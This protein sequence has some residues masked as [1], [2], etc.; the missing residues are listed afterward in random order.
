M[1][2]SDFVARYLEARGVT[3]TFELVGGMITHLLDSLSR[4]TAIQIVSCHHEQGA[5]FS[6]EGFARVSGVPGVALA[7]SGPGATNLLTSIGSC[8]F[9]STPAVFITGQV[10]THELKA[11]TGVRQLGFQ[12]TDIVT[13][14]RPIC[15]WAVQVR[16]AADLPSV[17]VTAF[18]VA[19]EG[20]QGPCLVDI[21]MNVQAENIP[22]ELADLAIEQARQWIAP[23]PAF[24]TQ[25]GV[26]AGR[27]ADLLEAIAR[28]E[29][30]LLLLGGGASSFQN[31]EAARRISA[32][33]AIP[34]V[35]SLMAVDVLGPS[36]PQRVG[37]I[38]S[39]G[40][41][42]ANKILGE[43]DLLVVVGSRLD[44]RQTG[45]D[46]ES[47]CEGKQI[48]QV[49]VDTAEI[50]VRIKPQQAVQASIAELAAAMT[51]ATPQPPLGSTPLAWQHR[52]TSLRQQFP[53]E[54]E[55]QAGENEI[56]PVSLLQELCGAK[57]ENRTLYVTDVGQHQMWAAQSLA[58]YRGDRFLTSG[59]MGAMGFGLPA[60]IGAAMAAPD[61]CTILVS[62]DGSFQLNLQELE[63]L[64]R[65]QL[66]LKI[67]LFNNSCHGM[68][69]QFQESYF[70]DN[71]QSTVT[72][73]SAPD[74][75]AVAGAY[76]IPAQRLDQSNLTQE[77]LAG[78]LREPGPYL[79]EVT[80]SQV[81]KVYPKLAFG[82][83]FGEM[84]PESSP[85]SMEST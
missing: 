84:E 67:L 71:L 23:T 69:R 24:S 5:G 73:Y 81:S 21:P 6:A 27:V 56:N 1:K 61:A 74:F 12:E 72:G 26:L 13:M 34:V 19:L 52:I 77:A 41:R 76:G 29:R 64:F 46:L 25:E 70:G 42:W 17:L 2:A 39:Y 37:F 31:R 30:P 3:H 10:N 66:N 47:F 38:G 36:D 55:F 68:V 79:L 18:E 83:R 28:A 50:G 11:E 9:D 57:S 16:Q 59:G 80:L 35:L 8:Y 15:K 62:G 7:T 4:T 53:A 22:P 58:F 60:A 40:N 43:A 65:N 45:A 49:D 32:H 48:W 33:L 14:A 78:M 82:R 63:T 51:R 20:R 85:L 44:I 75:V 54:L